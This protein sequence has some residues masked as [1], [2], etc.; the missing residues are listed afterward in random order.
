LMATQIV[1]RLTA[2]QVEF[3]KVQG[4][5]LYQQPVLPEAKFDRLKAHFEGKLAKLDDN[6]RPEAMVCPHLTD[7]LLFEWLFADEILD[8]VEPLIGP[9]IAF[10]TSHFLCKPKGNGRRV[11]W[12]EDSAYW[13]TE[14]EPMDVATVWLAID[15]SVRENGCMKVVPRTHNNGYSDYE[16]VDPEVNVFGS[17]IKNRCSYDV[18]SVYLEL[19][20]NQ[21]SIHHAKLV[22][23]SDPNGSATRRC[24]YTMRYVS[25]RCKF[26]RNYRTPKYLARGQDRAGNFYC[27]PTK[28]YHDLARFREKHVKHGH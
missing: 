6:C 10:F 16:Y 19:E 25:T 23:G 9:D 7:P 14:F 18:R 24:G 27:D 21:A 17:E 2:E 20:P 8:L 22:H 4:Y 13:G 15:H 3:Y 26:D 11:P 5:V 1:P 12:H 28:A